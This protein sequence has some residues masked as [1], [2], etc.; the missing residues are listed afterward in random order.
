MPDFLERLKVTGPI[1]MDG[2]TGTELERRGAD[3]TSP[4]WSA[5]ALLDSPA[6]LEQIH[7]D[8]LEAGAEML[9][10]N[11]FRTQSRSLDKLGVGDQAAQLTALAVSIA[12]GAVRKSGK[13]AFVA[14]SMAPLEDSYTP[15]DQP[16]AQFLSE[17]GEIANNLASAGVDLL[18]IETMNTV[19]EAQAAAE[20]AQA[21]GLPFGVSFVCDKQGKLISGEP[22]RAAVVAV[23]PFGP[24]FFSINCTPTPSLHIALSAL[25]AATDLP[26]AA[27]GNAHHT[28]DFAHWGESEATHP[29]G[30]AHYAAEW[31][32]SD[33]KLIGGCCGTTPEH[34]AAIP[35][36][37]NSLES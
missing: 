34:I 27:Y 1:L 5:L 26:I 29:E 28:E 17:H 21:T 2:A 14:G 12:Q 25:R 20:A 18:M 11:T 23:S 8:Y 9:I 30:Y 7:L 24:S 3:T 6:L 33:A 19:K 13:Q 4:I 16:Y 36:P 32:A 15:Y 37:E 10:A 31:L 22:L 35:L